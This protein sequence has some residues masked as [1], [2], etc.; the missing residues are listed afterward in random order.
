M[1]CSGQL[2]PGPTL[3]QQVEHPGDG[4]PLQRCR[5]LTGNSHLEVWDVIGQ[6]H[7]AQEQSGRDQIGTLGVTALGAG[8]GRR[9]GSTGMRARH[10]L[11]NRMMTPSRSAGSST[12]GT[13]E[14]SLTDDDWPAA[15]DDGA[16]GFISAAA[17]PRISAAEPP[18]RPPRQPF[19]AVERHRAAL[20]G[21]SGTVGSQS[22]T[23]L[24][25]VRRS[26]TEGP[27]IE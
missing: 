17:A 9:R 13:M 21:P 6:V 25:T 5:S 20:S 4:L 7:E 26:A 24:M 19:Q 27:P 1:V 16:A 12:D 23:K 3:H 18:R 2:G 10:D 15:T 11:T 22:S 14:T 8:A